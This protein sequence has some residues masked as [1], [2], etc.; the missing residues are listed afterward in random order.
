MPVIKFSV[1]ES[2]YKTIETN[3][4]AQK[5]RIPEFVR[6]AVLNTPSIF[7]PIEAEKRALAQFAPGVEFTLP[8]IYGEDWEGIG[9][10]GGGFGTSFYNYIIKYSTKIEFVRYKRYAIYKIK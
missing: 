10:S 6:S 4:N 1:S 5:M 9:K 2:D 3:A 8:Q 7:T